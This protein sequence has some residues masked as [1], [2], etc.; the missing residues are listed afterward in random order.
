MRSYKAIILGGIWWPY[1]AKCS[2][3]Q[4]YSAE[5]KERALDKAYSAGDFSSVADVQLWQWVQCEH[6]GTGHW[7]IAKD[8]DN[9]ENELAYIDTVS[10]PI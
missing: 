6:C 1:G 9:E 5:D 4:H 2:L 10:E 3:E 7:E 8:W